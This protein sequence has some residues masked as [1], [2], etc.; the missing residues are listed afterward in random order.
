MKQK[1]LV[2]VKRTRQNINLVVPPVYTYAQAHR[3]LNTLSV[4]A[5]THVRIYSFQPRSSE[6]IFNKF[7]LAPPRTNRQLSESFHKLST[8]F[9]TA[10]TH[11]AH[12]LLRIIK[13]CKGYLQ[14]GLIFK[15]FINAYRKSWSNTSCNIFEWSK[16]PIFWRIFARIRSIFF[17]I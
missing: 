14:C 16:S 15:S 5:R 7:L 11:I 4:N 9:V 10:F 12:I 2:L 3:L 13:I 17:V 8:V 6:V 1:S